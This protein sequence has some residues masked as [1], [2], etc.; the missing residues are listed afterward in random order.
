MSKVTLN[1]LASLANEAS[2]IASIN[3]NNT[4]LETAFDNTLSRDGSSPNTMNASLDMN[5]NRILNLPGP[6]NANEPARLQDIQDLAL[7]AGTGNVTGSGSSTDKTI[8]RFSGTSGKSLQGSGVTV[9]DADEL[10]AASLS[11]TNAATIGT[12][13]SIGTTLGVTGASTL[14]SLGVTQAATVGTT[15]SVTGAATVGSLTVGGSILPSVSAS[16]GST[17]FPWNVLYVGNGGSINF[18]SGGVVVGQSGTTLLV[19]ASSG[20]SCN[21]SVK[22]TSATA[23]IGYATGSGGTVTQATSKSTGVTLNTVSGSVTTNNAALAAN[24]SVSFV[25]T[26]STVA[27][28]DTVILN[29]ASGGT[30]NAY[31][32][33]VVAV[34]AGSFTIRMTNITV[35]SLS[36]ALVINYTIIKGVTS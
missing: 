7:T 21:S 31:R 9:S 6:E 35:G 33:D 10:T 2:A 8:P 34:A 5:S 29:W 14:N 25:V 27:A 30:A 3:S 22:S 20:L 32:I 24:T 12:S 19:Q 26:N 11:V 28:T 1:D 13:L 23:G 36:E 17:S 4:T 16:I 18:N 15:L